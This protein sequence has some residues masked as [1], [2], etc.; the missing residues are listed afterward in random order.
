M[1]DSYGSYSLA[2]IAAVTDRNRNYG[3]NDGYGW[4]DGN[5]LWIILLLLFMGG[6]NGFGNW[7]E[8]GCCFG[9]VSVPGAT[10]AQVDQLSAR[11]DFNALEAAIAGNKDAIC[12]LSKQIGCS[13]AEV[14]SSICNVQSALQQASAATNLSICQLQNAVQAGDA[15]IISTLQNC[16]CDIK[17]SILQQTNQ[18]SSQLAE[19]C[20]ENRLAVCQTNNNIDKGFAATNVAL[21]NGFANTAF[22]AERNTDRLI[23]NQNANTDKILAFL[24]NDKISTLQERLSAAAAEISQRDQTA[25]IIK[26]LRGNSCGCNNGCGCGSCCV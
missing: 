17:T 6:R 10:Q 14:Q 9:Q 5:C 21:T 18:L 7:G 15:S 8:N 25:A 19:C 22:A 3:C 11:V 2:D 23:Q 13:T 20:C 16:C 12:E 4:G 1:A 24:T 26:A